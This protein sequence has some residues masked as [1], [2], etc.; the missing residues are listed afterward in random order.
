MLQRVLRDIPDETVKALVDCL[1]M[2]IFFIGSATMAA[3]EF[4]HEVA[5]PRITMVLSGK[6][7]LP[8]PICFCSNDVQGISFSWEPIQFLVGASMVPSALRE[9]FL[10]KRNCRIVEYSGCF[11]FSIILTHL[12]RIDPFC[13]FCTIRP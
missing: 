10:A 5:G 2:I 8:A 6:E 3:M 4:A 1:V 11:T 7:T 13:V 12:E 9:V